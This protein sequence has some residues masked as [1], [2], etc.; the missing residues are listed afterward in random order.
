MR[1]TILFATLFL[2]VNGFSQVLL[3]ADGPGNT[4][5]LI[6]SVL[7]PGYNV[8]E[9]PDCGHTGFGEHIDE[10]FDNGLNA[11]AFR[12]ILH[13]SPDDDRCINTDR[14][15]TEIK[16][17]DKSPANLLGVENETVRYQWKFKLP[18]GFQSSSKFT[19]IHQLKSVGDP[20]DSMPLYTLTTRKGNPDR[21]ELR[22]AE[23]GTQVT[24]AQTGL[25]PF[26]GEWVVV[27]EEIEYSNPGAY[28]IELQKLSDNSTLFTYSDQSTANWRVGATFIRPKWGI[29]RSLVYAEDLR[30]E[31]LLFADFSIEELSLT[32][33]EEMDGIWEQ[34]QISPNPASNILKIS[35]IP[36]QLS[37]IQLW[38]EEGKLLIEKDVRSIATLELHVGGFASGPY[39]L[40]CIGK[41]GNSSQRLIL[42]SE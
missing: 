23:L 19:H 22:Y 11:H 38:N 2:A 35:R 16:T 26:L 3:N 1:I 39:I 10:V 33:S 32:A 42:Q 9:T 20:Y 13:V 36:R 34:L 6:N 12:F 28:T 8:I 14:Q 21:L 15:R 4:Y 17:Y 18:T 40:R 27:T 7:A 24:L 31:E 5:D 25:A 41:A 30:D 29:Y 37:Q